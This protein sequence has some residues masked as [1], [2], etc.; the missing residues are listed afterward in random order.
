MLLVQLINCLLKIFFT[1]KNNEY[2]KYINLIRKVGK[3]LVKTTRE[4]II[5]DTRIGVKKILESAN[6]SFQKE[7]AYLLK[8][9][10]EV[11]LEN[12]QYQN[13]IKD[14]KQEISNIVTY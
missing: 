14:M 10:A 8:Q 3:R 11:Q 13:K 7:I 6:E 5:E 4:K 9:Y 2:L 1:V 12:E